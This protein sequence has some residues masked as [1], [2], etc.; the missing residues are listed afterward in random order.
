MINKPMLSFCLKTLTLKCKNLPLLT[1]TDRRV[2]LLW[3]CGCSAL[4]MLSRLPHVA[5]CCNIV[6][7]C[8][9]QFLIN[10][11]SGELR[12]FCDVTVC[13]DP[14]RKLSSLLVSTSRDP[15]ASNTNNSNTNNDIGSNNSRNI[16]NY[17]TIVI[18]IQQ[19]HTHNTATNHQHYYSSSSYYYY[20]DDTCNAFN[21]QSG[22][23]CCGASP[24]RR[25]RR[26]RRR[27]PSLE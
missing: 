17:H 20:T 27:A 8:C 1:E 13:P 6:V 7:T 3:H 25:G 26:P 19:H 15:G 14:V 11:E 12:H 21:R 24:P 16:H 23:S 9:K 4:R 18:A 5:T 22:R 10:V 2:A